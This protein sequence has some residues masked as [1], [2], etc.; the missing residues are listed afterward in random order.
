MDRRRLIRGELLRAR[1][2]LMDAG[3][4]RAQLAGLDERRLGRRRLASEERRYR[5]L[6]GLLDATDSPRKEKENDET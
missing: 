2:R 5:R 4:L 3:E 1:Y 6:R